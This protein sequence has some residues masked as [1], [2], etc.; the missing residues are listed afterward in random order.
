MIYDVTAMTH[1]RCRYLASHVSCTS[2]KSIMNYDDGGV[3]N[4]YRM[5]L[6]RECAFQSR[7]ASKRHGKHYIHA[8]CRHPHNR[9]T[10]MEQFYWLDTLLTAISAFDLERRL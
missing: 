10:L 3:H 1:A 6:Q 2:Y 7:N 5:L 8:I 4:R 9:R